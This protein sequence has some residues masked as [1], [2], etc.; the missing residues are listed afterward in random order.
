MAELTKAYK[1]LVTSNDKALRSTTC[2]VFKAPLYAAT[3]ADSGEMALDIFAEVMPDLMFLDIHMN[4]MGGFEVLKTLRCEPEFKDVKIILLSSQNDEE[5]RLKG[6]ELGADD[7]MTKPLSGVELMAK[8]KVFMRMTY[9]EEKNVSLE[10]LVQ[11]EVEKYKQHEKYMFTRAKLM[12]MGDMVLAIA[13]HWRQPLNSLGIAIQDIYDAYQHNELT[14]DYLKKSVATAMGNISFMSAIIDNFQ[15]IITDDKADTLF[16]V[17]YAVRDVTLL[18]K[19]RLSNE[20]ITMFINSMTVETY[21]HTTSVSYYVKGRDWVLK[22]ALSNLILNTSE[23]ITNERKKDDGEEK[24][25]IIKLKIWNVGNTICISVSGNG[26]SVEE[27]Y[28][29]RAFEPYYNSPERLDGAGKG[30]DLYFS[31]AIVEQQLGGKIY[32]KLACNKSVKFFIEIPSAE[33]EL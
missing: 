33:G 2:S 8:T 27:D 32:A 16:N 24:E 11:K 14:E 12:S 10:E 21:F 5:E 20:N 15:K 31:R 25:G 26:E 18:H 29:E 30:L 19:D 23:A 17:N 6:Y 1:I 4:G 22:Q 7:Y 28:L 13:H 9:I 3:R